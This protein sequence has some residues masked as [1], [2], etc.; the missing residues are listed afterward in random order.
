MSSSDDCRDAVCEGANLRCSFVRLVEVVNWRRAL[1]NQHSNQVLSSIWECGFRQNSESL[2]Q[3]N[4]AL[5]WMCNGSLKWRAINSCIGKKKIANS[6][7]VRKAVIWLFLSILLDYNSSYSPTWSK[8]DNLE[9]STYSIWTCKNSS[10]EIF[11]YCM[12]E[13]TFVLLFSWYCTS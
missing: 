7:K 3:I 9:L 10:Q 8:S 4:S 1:M 5:V 6:A 13:Y 2:N 12:S 11:S